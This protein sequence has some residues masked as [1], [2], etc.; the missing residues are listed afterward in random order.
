MITPG[1]GTAILILEHFGRGPFGAREHDWPAGGVLSGGEGEGMREG[2]G[3]GEGEGGSMLPGS[4][5][6]GLILGAVVWGGGSGWGLRWGE[7]K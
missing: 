7:V 2:V 1:G 5:G 3:M 6:I 4:A